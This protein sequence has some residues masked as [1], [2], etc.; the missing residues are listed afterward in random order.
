ML[1]KLSA[2]ALAA[3]L[4][5]ATGA[6][7]AVVRDYELNNSLADSAASGVDILNNGTLTATG[8]DFGANQGPT[9]TGLS[10]STYT[11]STSFELD[12]L[13]GFRKIVDFQNLGSDNGLY[14]LN[15]ALNY[16]NFSTGSAVFSAGQFATVVLTRDGATKQVTGYVDG[17]QQIQFTDTTNDALIGGNLRFFQDDNVTAH[18]ASGG[19]VDFIKISDSVDVPG[20]TPGVPEPAAW[21]LMIV[22]FGAAGSML[23]RRRGFAATA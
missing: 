17:V 20:R 21:A 3:A 2:A 9:V 4:L 8:I 22:G 16:Y 11:I 12:T 7:A 6:N 19:S 1:L 13:S 14:D 23:R 15:N 18:E 10:L 5:A